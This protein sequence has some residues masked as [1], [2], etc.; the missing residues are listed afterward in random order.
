MLDVKE[1]FKNKYINTSEQLKCFLGCEDETDS[2][3]HLMICSKIQNRSLIPEKNQPKYQDFFDEDTGKQSKVAQILQIQLE[4]R[5]LLIQ[6]MDR[7]EPLMCSQVYY[8]NMLMHFS[9]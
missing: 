8:N 1:N 6:K 3:E 2:Q 4:K 9:D 7:G 5:K